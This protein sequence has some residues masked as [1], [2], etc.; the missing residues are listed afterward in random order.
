MARTAIAVQQVQKNKGG[1]LTFAA[2]DQANGMSFPNDGN[3]LLRVKNTSG[4]PITVTVASVPCSHGRTSDIVQS[5]AATTG[6]AQIGP[7]DPALFNQSG[8][9]VN[10]DFSAATGV[11]VAAIKQ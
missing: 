7:L 1:A 11:T 9:V 5:V 4:S 2:A 3:T 6:D 10:V 8:A